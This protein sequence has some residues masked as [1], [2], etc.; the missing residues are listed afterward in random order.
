MPKKNS[1]QYLLSLNP[2]DTKDSSQYIDGAYIMGPISAEFHGLISGKPYNI[3][4]RSLSKWEEF[5]P[6]TIQYHPRPLGPAT[7]DIDD[8]LISTESFVTRWSEP[9][10]RTVFDGYHVQLIHPTS[11]RKSP[12]EVPIRKNGTRSWK[13]DE[14]TPGES[15]L[16]KISTV[17]GNLSS[18]PVEAN[19]TLKPLPVMFLGMSGEDNRM[20][21][22][23]WEPNPVSI[24]DRY[25]VCFKHERDLNQTCSFEVSQKLLIT[26]LAPCSNNTVVVTVLSG[27]MRSENRTLHFI[28]QPIP[29]TKGNIFVEDDS[30]SVEWK[31]PYEQFEIKW[32]SNVREQKENRTI[33]KHSAL[34]SNI[35]PGASYT[36]EIK[37]ICRKTRSE[38]L[39]LRYVVSPKPP[40]ELKIMQIDEKAIEVD[41]KAP[42]ESLATGYYLKLKAETSY[43]W[44]EF[45]YVQ[46]RSLINELIPG[47]EYI[48]ELRTEVF[49]TRS[50]AS[51]QARLRLA[52]LPVNVLNV[53]SRSTNT[54]KVCWLSNDDS[55]QDR[56]SILLEYSHEDYDEALLMES[57]RNFVVLDEL[58]QG[59]LHNVTVTAWSANKESVGRSLTFTA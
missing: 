19:V 55:I 2:P 46:P 21:W 10:E 22:I 27:K 25:F 4:V 17:S 45:H 34:I 50:D 57:R 24:Q 59:R 42:N 11:S 48:F 38:P 30:M 6:T 20:I 47:D 36:I 44:K 9:P 15:Y 51:L 53:C 31:S 3:S 43:I 40:E 52:P 14:L 5:H 39:R 18:W 33:W 58:H 7:I 1:S 29:P 8:D 49:D 28:A 56:F 16:M 35:F 54:V 13:F 41:W 32:K 26:D 23:N 12:T 37:A